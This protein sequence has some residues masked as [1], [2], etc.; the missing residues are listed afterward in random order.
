MG[1]EIVDGM[2]KN[3]LITRLEKP[4]LGKCSLALAEDILV[5][6]AVSC[7]VARN[8]VDMTLDLCKKHHAKRNDLAR[9]DVAP[10]EDYSLCK[11]D[12]E[13]LLRHFS[14]LSLDFLASIIDQ[15]SGFQRQQ[16]RREVAGMALVGHASSGRKLHKEVTVAP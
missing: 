13:F 12:F 14:A 5:G 10:C 9:F 4:V 7:V 8:A 3:L 11:P 1:L 6:R 16:G 15:P 2:L